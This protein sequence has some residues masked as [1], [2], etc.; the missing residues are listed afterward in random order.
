LKAIMQKETSIH[1]SA[2]VNPAAKLGE[3]VEV[4][5]FCIIEAGAEIGDGCILD[6]NVRIEGCVR[7]GADNRVFHGAALGGPPQDLKYSGEPSILR[8]GSSNFIREYVTMNPGTAAGEETLIGDH[9]LIMA[10]AHVAHNCV[11]GDRVILAN[12]VQ[13]AGHVTI[14]EHAI[15]GGLT[16]VHQFARIGAHC[17]V[18]GGSRVPQDVPPYIRAAGNPL[19]VAGLNLVGIQRRG[20]S[21]ESIEAIKKAY[22]I[23]YRSGLNTSQAITQLEEANF[24]DPHALHMLT[25]VRRSERGITK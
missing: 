16:P 19:V 22:R 8:I 15:L 6:S 4:G 2:I 17:F 5:P 12:A 18:G 10:Y 23:I 24:D 14:E 13:L 11:L 9:C 1:P 25:F 20:F 3:G 21:A 7:M